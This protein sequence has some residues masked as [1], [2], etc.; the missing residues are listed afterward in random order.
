ML[1]VKALTSHKSTLDGKINYFVFLVLLKRA[2]TQYVYIRV[3]LTF[4]TDII[5]S[6]PSGPYG[7]NYQ[8]QHK[9]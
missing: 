7:S 1:D 8:Q 4:N 9:S 2:L 3:N 5:N 6:N